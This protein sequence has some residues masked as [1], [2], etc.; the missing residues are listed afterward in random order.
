MDLTP[1]LRHG[2]APAVT[3]A[4]GSE[5]RIGHLTV[6][7]NARSPLIGRVGDVHEGTVGELFGRGRGA[8]ERGRDRVQRYGDPAGPQ[9]LDGARRQASVISPSL[10]R[11]HGHRTADPW[12]STEPDIRGKQCAVE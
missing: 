1:G 11:D 7:V 6:G 12:G 10:P 9:L 4:R 8:N 5:E 3:A 2:G